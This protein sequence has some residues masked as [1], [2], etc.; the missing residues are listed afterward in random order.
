VINN[1]TPRRSKKG[2]GTQSKKTPQRARSII[3]TIT[4][5]KKG[6]YGRRDTSREGAK[7][8]GIVEKG[9]KM[10]SLRREKA[11]DYPI[12]SIRNVVCRSKEARRKS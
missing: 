2:W 1:W 5:F 9:S 11:K 7:L 6:V 10:L 3:H 12:P 4:R 8:A